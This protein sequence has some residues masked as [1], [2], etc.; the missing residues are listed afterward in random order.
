[1]A[2]AA[3]MESNGVPIDTATFERLKHRWPG[4]RPKL[5]RE[6]DRDF[7]VYDGET[8]KHD[9]FAAFLAQHNI[10]W[11]HLESGRLDLSDD[12]FRIWPVLGRS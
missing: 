6:I 11:P 3:T 12:A 7:G 8:F 9:R 2:A 1:M 10:A 4:L 5:I